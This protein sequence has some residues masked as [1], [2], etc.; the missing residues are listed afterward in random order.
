LE[1]SYYHRLARP[2]G[3]AVQRVYMDDRSLDE[4][5]AVADRDVVLVPR[6]HLLLGR[7]TDSISTI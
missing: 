4:T 1:E 3:F 6:G 2:G 5:M 7:L